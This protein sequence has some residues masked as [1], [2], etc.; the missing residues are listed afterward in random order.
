[1]AQDLL[2]RSPL[3]QD[4]VVPGLPKSTKIAQE[5]L[6]RR[7]NCYEYRAEVLLMTDMDMYNPLSITCSLQGNLEKDAMVDDIKTL[8]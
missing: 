7:G 1:M 6:P 8:L 4:M 5:L 3:N 2:P